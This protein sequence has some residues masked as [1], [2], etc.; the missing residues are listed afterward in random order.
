MKRENTPWGA[1]PSPK[2]SWPD[3]GAP[4]SEQFSD[5]YYSSEDGMAESLHVFLT[6]NLLPQ[7]WADFEDDTFCIVETGFGTGLNF[8]LTW[9]LWQQQSLAHARLHY[10]SVE[11]FPLDAEELKRTVAHWGPLASL[12][13]QL[14]AAWPGRL[15]G[16]HRLEFDKG[17]VV[18]DLWWED[19]GA[20][21]TDMAAGSPAVDAWF[22]DGFAPSRNEAMWQPQLYRAMAA[23]SRKAATV[24]TF[25]AASH[26]R[27]GLTEAGFEVEKVPG[28]GHKRE[29]LRGVATQAGTALATTESPWDLPIQSQSKPRSA[30]IVG[31]GLAGCT[32]A[33]A[34]AQRGIRVTLMDRGP[35]A[36]E[37]SGN[38]QGVLY[39]RLSRRHSALTDFALQSFRYSANLYRQMFGSGELALGLDGELCGSF[40]QVTN[41][42]EIAL[43]KQQL[44]GLDSLAQ[45]LTAQQAGQYLGEVPS[46]GG[47]WYPDSGWLSPPAVC[48][49]MLNSPLITLQDDCGELSINLQDGLWRV[50]NEHNALLAS[51]DTAILC[52]GTSTKTFGPTDWLPLQ[53]IRGQ[54]TYLPETAATTKLKSAFC[55]TGYI[56]PA[57]EGRH[58]MGASFKL[59]DSSTKVRPQEHRENLDKLA[60]ALPQWSSALEKIDIDSLQGRVGFRCASPDYLPIAGPVPDRDEFLQ[61]YAALR[62]NARQTIQKRGNY[63]PG[64]YV[65][66]AHGS[67]GL[68]SAPLCAQLLASQICGELPPLS[69]ELVRALSPARFLVRDLARSRI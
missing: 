16:Q 1:T 42:Q 40:H 65:N 55:H 7:R 45:A 52:T 53:I 46:E 8:L 4:F 28:F 35:L 54:T 43:L 69:R 66:T 34:L 67:R 29:S 21:L 44:L 47:F 39:T 60:T 5:V 26:V 59:R 20:A 61:T 3:G 24:S 12:A 36:G 10:V 6:G 19:C 18:L 15:P 38:E 23:I 64:L 27:R 62:K 48:S 57:R 49:A 50:T 2:V 56:A 32:L 22:L 14:I 17:R 37:A 11:K 13:D 9:Q 31:A 30:V 41:E 58:C 33:S 63:V 51:A 68:S 25:T